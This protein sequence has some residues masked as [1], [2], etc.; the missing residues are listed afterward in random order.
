MK[1][2]KYNI[3]AAGIYVN[4]YKLLRLNGSKLTP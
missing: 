3:S 4:I 1:C 2:N